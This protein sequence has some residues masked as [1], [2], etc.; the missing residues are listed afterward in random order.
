[1]T[2]STSFIKGRK[3]FLQIFQSRISRLGVLVF[4]LFFV[5][6]I[7]FEQHAAGI[8]HKAWLVSWAYAD[9]FHP[10]EYDPK[11]VAFIA[12]LKL[13][14]ELLQRPHTTRVVGLRPFGEECVIF[15]LEHFDPDE[16]IVQSKRTIWVRWKP[17]TMNNGEK[18]LHEAD[19]RRLVNMRL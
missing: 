3:T 9:I 15:T 14:A 11:K 6:S 1:M 5:S 19:A 4:A 7:L 16:G 10:P 17:W 2:P 8:G 13:H 12:R 18:I